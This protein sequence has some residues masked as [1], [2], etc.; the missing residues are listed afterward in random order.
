VLVRLPSSTVKRTR[1]PSCLAKTIASSIKLSMGR[2]VRIRLVHEISF[3]P[4]K[5]PT[6][7]APVALTLFISQYLRGHEQ[8]RVLLYRRKQRFEPFESLHI[9]FL[10]A[11]IPPC[12]LPAT[13]VPRQFQHF[14][15]ARTELQTLAL[16]LARWYQ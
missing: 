13:R 3:I 8:G 2:T 11:H 15:L 9:R 12:R 6:H 7:D 16:P 4:A 5:M 10:D 14:R 1:R